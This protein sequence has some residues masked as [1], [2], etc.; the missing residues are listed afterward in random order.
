MKLAFSTNAFIRWDIVEAI[1]AIA[2]IGYE[3]VELMFDAPHLW[4]KTTTESQLERVRDALQRTGL[5]IS[6]IN[7]FMMQAVGDP[8]QPYWHPSW[9]E[10]DAAY[11][12]IRIQHTID[13]LRQAVR[14]GAAHISTEPGGP[15]Y[16][17]PREP[18]EALFLNGL[19][20]AAAV[21]EETGVA[22]LIE[23]E[24]ELLI[25]TAPQF[26][27][28]MQR[29]QSPAIA[30]NFDVGHQFCVAE[31]PAVSFEALLPYVRHVHLEDIA[32]SRRHH[33]LIPGDGAID[34]P[35]FLR[36]ARE[37]G[38]SGWVT[39]ELYPYMDNPVEAARRAFE[40]IRPMMDAQ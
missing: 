5:R 13:S 27:R 35:G 8:R 11:R 1:E 36:R 40:H 15:L 17:A 3:G 18:A 29:V 31:D 23:P 37:L 39:I 16:G 7:A 25:E 20:R 34:I 24:P 33:H 38:Y 28:F 14:L 30:L 32:A 2:S 12:E 22:L 26:A 6:N 10:P 19:R 9:I 4:P 21:A